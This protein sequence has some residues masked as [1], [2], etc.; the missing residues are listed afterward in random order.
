MRKPQD[1][2]LKATGKLKENYRRNH[3]TAL[4]NHRNPEE[5]HTGTHLKTTGNHRNTSENHRTIMKKR[6]SH[7]KTVG[8][9]K[10]WKTTGKHKENVSYLQM[11]MIILFLLL[12]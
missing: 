3:R 12:P 9:D 8:I 1:N 5:T 7:R 10:R 2:H 11:A 6:R 4:E